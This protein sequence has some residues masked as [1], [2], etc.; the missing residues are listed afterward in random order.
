MKD[1]HRDVVRSLLFVRACHV[2]TGTPPFFRLR[3][4]NLI[5]TRMQN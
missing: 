4:D 1:S 2:P 3:P 5:C